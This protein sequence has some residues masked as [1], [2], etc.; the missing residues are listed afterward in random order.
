MSCPQHKVS[1]MTTRDQSA[2]GTPAT[3][4]PVPK[5]WWMWLLVVS[6]AGCI[7]GVVLALGTTVFGPALDA[8]WSFV[9]GV[10][11][12]TALSAADRV[13]FNV[14]IAVG[15]GLQAGASA[16]IAF[17]AV[18]PLRR[19]E[20]W[21]WVACVLGLALWLAI[22]TGLTLWYCLNGYPRLWPK[23]V[24][25]LGFVV[26]FGVPYAAMYRYCR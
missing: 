18:H 23:V 20:R 13:M 3:H 17:M 14:A 25:D 16:I 11:A 22:D 7:G 10:D 24:N 9:F 12:A 1:E 15:G 5:L 21:A 4:I 8:I 26:M 19:G 6:I 2:D